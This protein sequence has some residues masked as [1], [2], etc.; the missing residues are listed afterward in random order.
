MGK[1]NYKKKFKERKRKTVEV[2]ET[3]FDQALCCGFYFFIQLLMLI[4]ESSSANGMSPWKHSCH[5]SLNV[6]ISWHS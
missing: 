3:G 6:Y 1:N 5:Y 2:E 4:I